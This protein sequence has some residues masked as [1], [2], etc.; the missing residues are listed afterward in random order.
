[1]NTFHVFKKFLKYCVIEQKS[2]CVISVSL[3]TLFECLF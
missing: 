1:M 3:D 2:E